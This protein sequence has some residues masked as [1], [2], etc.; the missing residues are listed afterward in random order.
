MPSLGITLASVA[1]LALDLIDFFAGIVALF[2]GSLCRIGEAL[3]AARRQLIL[4]QDVDFTSDF[5]LLQVSE[6]KMRFRAARHQV[7][8]L[9]QPRCYAPL[10]P[11]SGQAMRGDSKSPSRPLV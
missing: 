8:R 9:D 7:A 3:N 4:P 2:W 11:M 5:A 1:L 10:W 6:P